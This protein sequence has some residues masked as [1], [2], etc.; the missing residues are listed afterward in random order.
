[1]PLPSTT[2]GMWFQAL[3]QLADAYDALTHSAWRKATL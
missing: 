2:V 1:M 3:E